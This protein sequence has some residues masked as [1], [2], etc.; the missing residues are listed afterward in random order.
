VC[1]GLSFVS[2]RAVVAG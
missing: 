1:N 2:K